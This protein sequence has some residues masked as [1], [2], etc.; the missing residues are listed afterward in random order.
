MVKTSK[1]FIMY[2]YYV[3][4]VSGGKDQVIDMQS[5]LVPCI[6]KVKLHILNMLTVL[7]RGL[8]DH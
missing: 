3:Y 2:T 8:L 7:F 5:C 4:V 6:L 1:L